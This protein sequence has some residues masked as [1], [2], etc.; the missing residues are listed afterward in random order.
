MPYRL[1]VEKPIMDYSKVIYRHGINEL[2]I[3]GTSTEIQNRY[4]SKTGRWIN[5]LALE[6]SF[7]F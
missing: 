1:M 4:T 2:Q 5:P 3:P 7:K 6:F